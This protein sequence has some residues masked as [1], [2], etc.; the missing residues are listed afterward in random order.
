MLTFKREVVTNAVEVI[1]DGNENW[2]I[3]KRKDKSI[4]C[5]VKKEEKLYSA[6]FEADIEN[7]E[8]ETLKSYPTETEF[9]IPEN[10]KFSHKAPNY[11][12]ISFDAV[13]EMVKQVPYKFEKLF[14]VAGR[15]K[16]AVTSSTGIDSSS[17]YNVAY[18]WVAL[19]KGSLSGFGHASGPASVE[20]AIA[21]AVEQIERLSEVGKLKSGKYKVLLSPSIAE[22]FISNL[23]VHIDAYQLLRKA[24]TLENK[25]GRMIATSILNLKSDPSVLKDWRSQIDWEG[26]PK[27]KD[28]FIQNGIFTNFAGDTYTSKK[29][30]V[31]SGSRTGLR[32]CSPTPVVE[33][34]VEVDDLR[35]CDTVLEIIRT[36]EVGGVNPYS[37][38]YSLSADGYIWQNGEFKGSFLNVTIGD[39]IWEM[40]FKIIGISKLYG[41]LSGY[42]LI[43]R[44]NV[45]VKD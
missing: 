12:H 37:G 5:V 34:E 2:R 11:K 25:R 27:Q 21:E 45:A 9:E 44:V 23:L 22:D 20:K 31:K 4:T 35:S 26:L 8:E 36:K 13:Q 3:Q 10:V 7:P 1:Y 33:G 19:A 16:V 15:E 24:S 38:N 42:I 41:D 17:E 6:T 40:L 28:F 43:D 18:C 14:Y 39:N 32:T 30:G 29:L